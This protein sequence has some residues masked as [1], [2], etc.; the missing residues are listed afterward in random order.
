MAMWLVRGGKFGEH[1]DRFLSA[2]Q[3]CLTWDNIGEISFSDAKGFEEIRALAKQMMP[4]QSVPKV[5]ITTSQW[6]A[7][8][9]GMKKGDLVIMPRKHKAVIAI[10]EIEGDHRFDPKADFWYWH[11]RS[12]KWIAFDVPR[13]S[14]D[15]DILFSFGAIM[16]I[17]EIK[18][19]DAEKRVRSLIKSGFTHGAHKV[20]AIQEPVTPEEDPVARDMEELA[21]DQIARKILARFKGHDMAR[22]VG[23]ILASQ[24]YR[25]LVSPP[26]P[27]K[28]VDILASPD[29]M[30]FGHPRICVQVKSTDG[31]VDSPTFN[32]LI[33]TMQ[34]VQ[35]EHGLL[36]S[37]GGFKATVR[38]Q[39]AP[40]YFKV[41]LWDQGD[42]I[43]E[44]LRHYDR[45]DPDLQAEIPLKKIWALADPGET[46]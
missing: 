28:G 6:S 31:P 22:L 19:N 34:N 18:R 45:L 20:P 44:L 12:V 40:N 14:F 43:E 46:E 39:E 5:S 16:T 1:E 35:A 17:C 8:I 3:I 38:Q 25:T 10:G 13:A 23:G 29:P 33:G 37:W 36:V 32:Q 42:L 2:N 24:G 11:S 21:L 41:R 7:F 27:D 26:G 4:G 9:L 15:K 30:G